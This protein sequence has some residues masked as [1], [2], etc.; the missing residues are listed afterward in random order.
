MGGEGCRGYG[1]FGRVQ[2]LHESARKVRGG[3]RQELQRHAFLRRYTHLPHPVDISGQVGCSVRS[4]AS[5]EGRREGRKGGPGEGSL[6]GEA[7]EGAAG[8][9]G[10]DEEGGEKGEE[11][12]EVEKEHRALSRIARV[13]EESVELGEFPTVELHRAP[14]FY[15]QK[16]VQQKRTTSFSQEKRELFGLIL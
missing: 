15:S 10:S 13:G 1:D 6:A 3:H 2:R 4:G 12:E 8:L 16:G 11:E 9:D 5:E 14:T 7:K